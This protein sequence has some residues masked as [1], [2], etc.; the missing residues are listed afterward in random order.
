MPRPRGA[1]ARPGR[2]HPARRDRPSCPRAPRLGSAGRGSS[3]PGR[4]PRR[5][6]PRPPARRRGWQ[7][8]GGPRLARP[9][10]RRYAPALA[11]PARRRRWQ[12]GR[13][14][15]SGRPGSS[16]PRRS[17]ARR[18]QR[19]RRRP[20]RSRCW[21]LRPPPARPIAGVV[22]AQGRLVEPGVEN[23][24]RQLMEELEAG[25]AHGGGHQ[26]LRPGRCHM[27][28]P[29]LSLLPLGRCRP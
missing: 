15:C 9:R 7:R 10:R 19:R 26:R 12:P 28:L 8:R 5:G 23:E 22:D 20:P 6:R 2:P 25:T 4:S 29:L 18:A 13:R 21:R 1:S 24:V 14:R 27:R 16:R 11:A 17:A 3:R